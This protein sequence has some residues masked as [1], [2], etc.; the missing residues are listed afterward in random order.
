MK[1][2]IVTEY[3]PWGRLLDLVEKQRVKLSFRIL[4]EVC[5]DDGVQLELSW[6]SRELWRF[7]DPRLGDGPHGPYGRRLNMVG[8]EDQNGLER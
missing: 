6:I 4:S 3:Q 5:G 2:H 7:L 8:G 1:E